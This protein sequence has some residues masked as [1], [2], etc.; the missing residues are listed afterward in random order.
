MDEKV[1]HV[2]LRPIGSDRHPAEDWR[3][4]IPPNL[5]A[6]DPPPENG[7]PPPSGPVGRWLDE[8]VGPRDF[9]VVLLAAGT[10]IG[11]LGL[12]RLAWNVYEGELWEYGSFWGFVVLDKSLGYFTCFSNFAIAAGVWRWRKR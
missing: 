8:D 12:V 6:S 10:A 7:P 2:D 4:L 5:R 3:A 1:I 11:L 9:W